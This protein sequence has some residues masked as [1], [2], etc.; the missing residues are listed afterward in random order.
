[1]Q[2]PPL[3]SCSFRNPLGSLGT[4]VGT[5]EPQRRR[6]SASPLRSLRRLLMFAVR[7]VAPLGATLRHFRLHALPAT[8]F[9]APLRAPLAGD[10][11]VP[12]ACCRTPSAPNL[13]GSLY[14]SA[15]SP[16]HTPT[17]AE[18]EKREA[19][20]P[21]FG[22]VIPTLPIRTS[23]FR[24]CWNPTLSRPPSPGDR[25]SERS[26][27]VRPRPVPQHLRVAWRGFR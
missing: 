5:S 4:E 25:R 22:G 24:A 15:I 9:S 17:S 6:A 10:S 1:M 12:T 7:S 13:C 11:E 16:R 27:C 18:Y 14:G 21:P 2:L 20:P 8:R 19:F 3:D 26:G 23:R